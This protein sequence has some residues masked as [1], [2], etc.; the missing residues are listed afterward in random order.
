MKPTHRN[1][2]RHEE[3]KYNAYLIMH[4]LMRRKIIYPAHMY[5]CQ[6]CD[7]RA[8]VWEH[9][10]YSKP[11][12]IYP[13]CFRCNSLLN[14]GHSPNEPAPRYTSQSK[15]FCKI[16]RACKISHNGVATDTAIM[17]RRA[18]GLDFPFSQ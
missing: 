13:A 3:W 4:A 5:D 16:T 2:I 8:E 11:F 9:R 17:I 14:C 7:A 10:D 12:D 18:I 15:L 1:K 6:L